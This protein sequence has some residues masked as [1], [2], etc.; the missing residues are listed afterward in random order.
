MKLCNRTEIEFVQ[1]WRSFLLPCQFRKRLQRDSR[2]LVLKPWYG[3]VLAQ[4]PKS[5]LL[6]LVKYKGR[7]SL[8]PAVYLR[9]PL[10]GA[11]AGERGNEL[12]SFTE[13]CKAG[14]RY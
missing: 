10:T 7:V 14:A 1:Y 11:H 6:R 12:R 4:F 8:I 13:C 3:M 5:V 2:F 9:K